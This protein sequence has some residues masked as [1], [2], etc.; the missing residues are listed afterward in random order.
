M[1]YNFYTGSQYL[2]IFAIFIGIWA[3][4]L[5][6]K[7]SLI[8]T[9]FFFVNISLLLDIRGL[10]LNNENAKKELGIE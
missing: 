2:I 6:W 10:L 5:G 4:N 9:G 3:L 7:L 8:L 1:K